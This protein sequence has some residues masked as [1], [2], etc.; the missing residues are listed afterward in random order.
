M[1]A[2]KAA[3]GTNATLL[4]TGFCKVTGWALYNHRNDKAVFLKLY[5]LARAPIVGTD[6]PSLK[7]G[8]PY[9][10]TGDAGTNRADST[11]T[12]G[13]K[14]VNGLA[15]AITAGVADTDTTAVSLDDLIGKLDWTVRTD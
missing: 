6:V 2:I 9:A 14:F 8:I 7:I 1:S 12:A 10:T 3:A 11:L 15:Y 5:D 4:F 13:H